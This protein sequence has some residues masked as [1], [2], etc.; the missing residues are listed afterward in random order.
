MESVQVEE[1]KPTTRLSATT[2][3]LLKDSIDLVKNLTLMPAL[4][5]FAADVFRNPAILGPKVRVLPVFWTL[6]GLAI[7]VAIASCALFIGKRRTYAGYV[8]DGLASVA[9]VLFTLGVSTG[10]L[11]FSIQYASNRT[12]AK[13]ILAPTPTTPKVSTQ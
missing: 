10:I 9:A 3:E 13:P 1:I 8:R 6:S 12:Q 7:L 4:L 2:N 5:I 11:V